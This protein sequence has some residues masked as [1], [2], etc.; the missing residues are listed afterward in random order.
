VEAAVGPY[1]FD[2]PTHLKPLFDAGRIALRGVILKDVQTGRIVGHLKEAG[3]LGQVLARLPLN[4][5]SS[6][7]ELA[8]LVAQNQSLAAIQSALGTVQVLSA[9]GAVAS[10][11]NLGVSVVGFAMVLTKL[12]RMDAKLD[13]VLNGL[14]FVKEQIKQA[15]F[16]LDAIQLSEL[17]AAADSL[18]KAEG[19]TNPQNRSRLLGDASQLFSKQRHY[20][21]QLLER[22]ALWPHPEVPVD[23]IVEAHARYV[24][25]AMGELQAEF[26]QG[27][28]G[29]YRRSIQMITEQHRP[30]GT[31]DAVKIF[32]TRSD[33]ALASGTE[34][35][36][37][38]LTPQLA[39]QLSAARSILEEDH[40]RI[41]SM[42]VEADYLQKH[43]LD[44]YEYLAELRKRPDGFVVLAA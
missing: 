34:N 31:I 21:F 18:E 38:V 37:K 22:A 39:Q 2:V 33:A 36:L 32:R 15:N 25:V 7:A 40:A 17:R 11:A 28:M 30:F 9:V 5:L 35:H 26:L 12:K 10:V 3:Q 13:Q 43:N 14:D 24:A 29:A 6:A 19:A 23:A 20:Y 41:E 8:N 16:T 4:P 42:T 1:L 44:P 27:D